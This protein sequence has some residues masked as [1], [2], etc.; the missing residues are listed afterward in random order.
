MADNPKLHVAKG[1]MVFI[2]SGKDKKKT[3]KVIEALPR[4][5]KVVVENVNKIKRHT[6]PSQSVPQGGIIVKEAPISSS[7]VML[8]CPLC[9][10]ATRIK[11]T[12][13]AN[14]NKERMCKKCGQV[15]EKK[16]K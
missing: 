6:K 13:L 12:I 5:G 11:T 10:K 3:G 16:I 14:G 1:D 15:I 4:K 7:K 8:V 2:L 9:D